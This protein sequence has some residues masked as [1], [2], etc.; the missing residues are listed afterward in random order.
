MQ[1]PDIW[2]DIPF[3]NYTY[4]YDSLLNSPDSLQH[5]ESM[6]MLR[7]IYIVNVESSQG[8]NQ[9][10]KFCRQCSEN[11]LPSLYSSESFT[12][13]LILLLL[14]VVGL[15]FLIVPTFRNKFKSCTTTIRLAT[16]SLALML[17]AVPLGS[18]Y[19]PTIF[20]TILGVGFLILFLYFLARESLLTKEH[21]FW[22]S[23]LIFTIIT[24]FI[25]L[26]E[27]IPNLIQ[28]NDNNNPLDCY[29]LVVST[30]F[31]LF[32]V[33]A[34]VLALQKTYSST[35]SKYDRKQK[36]FL[37]GLF[38]WCFAFL[39]YFIG[40]YYSGTQRSLLTSLFRPAL[41]ASKIFILADNAA[42]IT[43]PLRRSGVFMG[44]LSLAR[45]SG[46]LVSAQVIINLIGARLKASIKIWFAHCHD[47]S[48]YVF[49]GTNNASIYAAKSITESKGN[50]PLVVFVDTAEDTISK[51]KTTFGFGS[52]MSLFT[53]RKEA[54]EAVDKAKKGGLPV[55]LA[56]SSSKLE[57]SDDCKELS[58]IGLKQLER[59]IGESSRTEFFFLSEDESANIA[60]AKKLTELLK[61]IV[62]K[63]YEI[64][65]NCRNNNLSQLLQFNDYN[66]EAVDFA[67]LAIDQLK[68]DSQR[69][70]ADLIAFDDK[71]CCSSPFHSLVIGLNEVGEEAVNYLYEYGAFVN[72]KMSRSDFKCY[73]IDN[74]MHDLEG[75][76]Y[77][78]SPEFK[79]NDGK[80][81]Q[82]VHV[83]P[84]Y[85]EVGSEGFWNWL[86]QNISS[87]QFILISLR[88][89]DEQL[90]LA[91]EIYNL[92]IRRR[93]NNTTFPL[94]IY[95]CAYSY[96]SA[97]KLYLMA[98]TYSKLNDYGKVE[99]IP[100]GM[101]DLLFQYQN[102]TK[103]VKIKHAKRYCNSYN[104]TAEQLLGRRITWDDRRNYA[105]SIT[106]KDK[107][108]SILELLRMESQDISNEYHRITKI[109]I[110]KR[111]LAQHTQQTYNLQDL[112]D[113]LPEFVTPT[114]KADHI[115]SDDY[116][117]SLIENL[118]AMEHVRWIAS[119]EIMGF[120]YD[121]NVKKGLRSLLRKHP[122]MLDWDKLSNDIKLFD[123]AVVITSLQIEKDEEK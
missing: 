26:S 63:E 116:L 82:N 67:K 8:A 42:D 79:Y 52:L 78:R 72:H 50:K 55:L 51:S 4:P 49:F 74:N 58:S 80:R 86:D 25:N 107:L 83:T 75:H 97:S 81:D 1:S 123:I 7:D 90:S 36:L 91:D 44:M 120:Q 102:I 20:L 65:C 60:G 73:V 39:I 33:L 71:G 122:Y 108:A 32:T 53:H 31:L 43:L 10:I 92:A 3:G 5:A 110:I 59:L 114:M 54:F 77:L 89:E 56:I 121:A 93:S 106:S 38:S 48:L 84:L 14:I 95:A 88:N 46:F 23:L 103:G 98:D 96:N 69:T 70:L 87:L 29:F 27:P 16:V 24:A 113:V 18:D 115:T 9:F 66:I 28:V 64:Y 62:I 47:S 13:K 15:F 119:H 100:F 112:Y 68:S 101:S 12:I 105:H 19:F 6:R 104:I 118:A 109:S 21:L 99:L 94:R 40:T 2:G 41:S 111:A 11:W 76:L 30:A 37:W 61:T 17:L 45:L 85:H 57:D 22:T 34:F 117:N 35:E